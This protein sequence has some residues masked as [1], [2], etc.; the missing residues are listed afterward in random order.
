MG[1]EIPRK[2][3][4]DIRCQSP[5]LEIKL[6]T[7]LSGIVLLIVALGF[8]A[9]KESLCQNTGVWVSAELFERTEELL[10]TGVSMNIKVQRMASIHD[11]TVVFKNMSC[12]PLDRVQRINR[13]GQ[14][15]K[16]RIPLVRAN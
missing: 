2:Q 15:L 5:E 16:A 14:N 12:W 6:L 13:P 4:G 7:G 3:L 8:A 11:A 9:Q 1:F 10:V